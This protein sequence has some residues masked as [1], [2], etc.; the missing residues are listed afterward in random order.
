MRINKKIIIVLA[1]STALTALSPAV[2]PLTKQNAAVVQAASS[3]AARTYGVDVSSYQT[4][5]LTTYAQNG[6]Q[7]AIV[8]ITEGQSYQNPKAKSQIAT[9]LSNNLLPM[10]YHFAT[11]G[12]NASRAR[13]EAQYAVAAAQSMGLPAGS[14]IACDWESGDG[15]NIYGGKAAS[16]SGILSFMNVI[17]EAGY[18]PLVYSSASWLRN[19][20]DTESLLA[21]YPNCLWVASYASSGR[22]DNANFNY[23]P[24]MNGVAIWQ[25]TD[26][27][28]GLNVDGNI[29]LLPLSLTGSS[30]QAP[31]TA[32]KAIKAAADP[33]QNKTTTNSNPVVKSRK[34]VMHKAL[35]YDQQ[36]QATGKS[37]SAYNWVTVLGGVVE[38]NDRKFYKIG[39]NRYLALGNIDGTHRMLRH[40]AYV[41]NHKGWRRFEPKL[42]RGRSLITYGSALHIKGKRYY[43]IG[44][45]RY[46]KAGNF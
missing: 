28:R 18:Q 42:Y 43:R 17:K 26:N 25:F 27:W 19:N 44:K 3:V 14:Y 1:C 36:G 8:K 23:F 40:N 24:S 16:A 21:Q 45:N 34:V 20:I 22:L 5:N 2:L 35:V 15:N 39:N 41:Y 10:A 6:A 31:T 4:S 9:A 29:S 37:I 32:Q 46:L 11:F 33:S 38:I 7:F 13:S 12:A 30:S